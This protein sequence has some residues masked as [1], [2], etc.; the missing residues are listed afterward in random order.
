MWPNQVSNPGPLTCES[1]A[2]PTA[3]RGQATQDGHTYCQLKISQILISQI[4]LYLKEYIL[5]TFSIYM[6]LH[7]NHFL[8]NY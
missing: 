6:F 7:L 2:L 8:L 3:V 1:G 5:D 4:I